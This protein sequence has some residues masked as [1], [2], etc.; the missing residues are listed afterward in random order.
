MS[1]M[2]PETIRM[3]VDVSGLAITLAGF[4]FVIMQIRRLGQSIRTTAHAAIY[5]QAADFR[6]H[7]MTYP[8]LRKY[9]FDGANIE[10][11]HPDYER[12]ATLSEL[13]LNYLEHL[14]VQKS[15]FAGTDGTAWI[16]F[17]GQ[18]LERSPISRRRLQENEAAYSPKLLALLR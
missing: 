14:S 2:D 15:H 7:L 9:F 5:S 10:T 16:K 17:A 12:A 1:G 8:E 13:F 4:V 18:S 6:T 3:V 11:G